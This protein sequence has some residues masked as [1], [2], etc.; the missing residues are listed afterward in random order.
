MLGVRFRISILARAA[1]AAA[2][3][4]SP[5]VR[6]SALNSDPTRPQQEAKALIEFLI[7][8]RGS[9]ISLSEIAKEPQREPVTHEVF[10]QLLVQMTDGSGQ[11]PG[12]FEIVLPGFQIP[13]RSLVDR[14]VKEF[15]V[16]VAGQSQSSA[17]GYKI[18]A[19]YLRDSLRL[20]ALQSRIR[21][22]IARLPRQMKASLQA[23]NMT[24]VGL[25]R[26]R[27]QLGLHFFS[28]FEGTVEEARLR[29]AFSAVLPLLLSAEQ[30]EQANFSVNFD[31]LYL[32][33]VLMSYKGTEGLLMSDVPRPRERNCE[34]IFAN[35]LQLTRWDWSP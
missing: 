31:T 20:L 10:Y 18:L 16:L 17:T 12:L 32:R 3:I 6:G 24:L 27:Y 14:V 33:A 25:L 4:I 9:W 22:E 5:Q 13:N 23:L 15:D 29:R 2:L 34:S 7:G 21:T 19:H 11:L 28:Q 26:H 30:M 35:S 8:Q 1:F